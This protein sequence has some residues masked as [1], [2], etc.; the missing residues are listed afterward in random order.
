MKAAKVVAIVVAVLVVMVLWLRFA[1]ARDVE[2]M[3]WQGEMERTG[4]W[5]QLIDQNAQQI[6]EGDE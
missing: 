1:A 2:L 3:E 4:Q 6:L 5:Q